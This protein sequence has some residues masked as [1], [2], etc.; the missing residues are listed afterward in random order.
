MEILKQG[1]YEP[2]SVASQ[3]VML[4]AGIS[5]LVDDV[6]VTDVRSFLKGLV[7]QLAREKKDLAKQLSKEITKEAEEELKKFIAGYRER[8]GFS[9]TIEELRIKN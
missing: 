7:D 2:N 8:K 9:S 3:V 5:G 6:P 4:Y 1:Q